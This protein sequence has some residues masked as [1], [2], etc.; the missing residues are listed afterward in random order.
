MQLSLRAT[1]AYY[2]D[3]TDE[4]T[5]AEEVHVTWVVSYS[6]KSRAATQDQEF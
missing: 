3:P 4:E 1:Q 5:E 2:A 6:V